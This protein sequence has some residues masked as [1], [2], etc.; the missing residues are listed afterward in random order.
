MTTTLTFDESPARRPG[1]DDD[2]GG[3]EYEDDP[4]FPPEPGTMP[5]SAAW[6]QNAAQVAALAKIAPAFVAVTFSAG[7]PSVAAATG[8]GGSVV[9]GL[10]TVEDIGTG[11]TIVKWTTG[12][13]PPLS[14]FV[15]AACNSTTA[16]AVVRAVSLAPSGGFDRVQV[17]GDAAG[18]AG[19]YDFALILL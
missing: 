8:P 13:L 12:T 16:G 7:T 10:F 17:Y 2:L 6:N 4:V 9:P 19:D 11:N 5:A 15:I 1:L 3:A 18:V 14:G